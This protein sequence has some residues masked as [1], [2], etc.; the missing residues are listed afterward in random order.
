[1]D[2]LLLLSS[3][4]HLTTTLTA[5][6]IVPSFSHLRLHHCWPGQIT[7]M[8]RSKHNCA[9]SQLAVAPF[10]FLLLLLLLCELSSEACLRNSRHMIFCRP[11]PL[12]FPLSPATQLVA[13]SGKRE[14]CHC[15]RTLQD[16]T[17]SVVSTSSRRRFSQC[18]SRRQ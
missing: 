14:Q 7:H 4:C 3:T 5:H 6:I 16:T 10:Q 1:M 13:H 15:H 12:I 11:F 17:A 2:N 8:H 18:N 9:S